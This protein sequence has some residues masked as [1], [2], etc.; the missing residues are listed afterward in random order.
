MFLTSSA[1]FVL[2]LT[3]FMSKT[4]AMTARPK[5]ASRTNIANSSTTSRKTD[6]H[7]SNRIFLDPPPLQ[8]SQI[9][10]DPSYRTVAGIVLCRSPIITRDLH[11]FEREYYAYQ[12][13]LARIHAAAFPVEF[14]FKKGSASEKL[15]Q[16]KRD[17][18][19]SGEIEKARENG[20]VT[21][22]KTQM[23]LDAK[24]Q[25]L[26]AA[27][28]VEQVQVASRITD[29][30][31]RND[32]KSLDRALQRTLY[33]I[34]RKPREMHAWQF[35]Q[36]GVRANE[37]LHEAAKRELTEECGPDMDVWIVGRR[38]IGFYKYDFPEVI[39][40]DHQNYIGAKVFF[41]KGHI[42]A[43]Q[44][45]ID[46]EEVVD[47]AWVTK[48]EMKDYVHKEYYNVVKNMLSEL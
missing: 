14:Y 27:E 41:M 11:P 30:D 17:R 32:L 26:I 25:D 2:A 21:L 5:K 28:E 39:K 9:N 24:Q 10:I 37:Y 47:F 23:K 45:K 44:V 34:V 18:E 7:S 40:K 48:Q 42:F 15:W 3:A 20:L 33:L 29:A 46:R 12:R 6:S 35:P 19:N 16:E 43:G 36:G 31:R 13:H 1:R 8:Y 22:I 4:T 38:P